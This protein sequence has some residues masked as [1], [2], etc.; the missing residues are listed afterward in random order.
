MSAVT[1][2]PVTPPPVT[3]VA[4][5]RTAPPELGRLE[6]RA[7]MVGLVAAALAAAG[8]LLDSGQ[9]YRSYLVAWLLWAGVALGCLAVMLLHHLTR[10][11]WGLVVRR[12]LE[13]AAGTMPVLALLFVPLLL[14]LGELYLWAR[15]EQVAADE[16]LRQKA[17]YLNP[18]GFIGRAVVYLGIWSFF[19]LALA[20]LSRRQDETG[21][22]GLFRRMRVLAAV[23]L[24]VYC[25]LATFASVDWLMSL[26][27][28]WYS[29]IFGVYFVGGHGVSAFAFL[30]PVALLLS[31]R[32]PMSGVFQPRHFHDY[33]KLLLAFVMLWTYFAL[34]QLLI[35]WS[36]HLP[37][38][39]PWYLA[40]LRGGWQW[41]ALALAGFHFALPFVLLLSRDLKRDARRLAAVAVLLL[42]MRWVD[43][44]WLAAPSFGHGEHGA[45]GPLPHWLDPVT[46]VAVGGVWLAVF[47]G[48]LRRS[49][50]LPV[51]APG[52]AE[53]VAGK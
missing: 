16:L 28:H 39:I 36:G 45:H 27:P 7:W 3:P 21:E 52:L 47:A 18:A 24:P 17:A 49:P 40:R 37:E 13:A 33:G 41:V 32:E 8:F 14:G 35:I 2:P 11:A 30:I 15:P 20:R 10:G 34:S 38:E 50:L 23:G 44:Y 46:A 6:R 26:D 51:N 43:L 1:P 22:R 9:F 53:A 48:R 25:L 42:A 4:G 31:R 12:V 29:S 5:D 19:A